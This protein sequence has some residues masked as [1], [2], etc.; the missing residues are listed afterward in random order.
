MTTYMKQ[1]KLIIGLGNPGKKYAH[2]RHNAGFRCIELVAKKSGIQIKRSQC[3]SKVG[4]GTIAGVNVVL[5]RPQT[6]VNCSGVAV[7]GLMQK[8]RVSVEDLIIICDDLD[9]PTGKVRVR[10]NGGSGGHNGLKSII[11][12]TGSQDFCRVKVGIGRPPGE[13]KAYIDEDAVI[14]YVLGDFTPEEV[15]LI[16]PA[17]IRASEA[18]ECILSE[19]ITAAMNKFN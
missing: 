9:L 13:Q 2:N 16:E 12:D 6:F 5:A 18:V 10:Q 3:Q 11:A 14:N 7:K 17:V 8:Y 4:G 1:M 19:G 15:R